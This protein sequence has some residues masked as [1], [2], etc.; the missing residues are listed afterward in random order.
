MPLEP[1]TRKTI[2]QGYQ[3]PTQPIASTRLP[4]TCPR[5]NLY[6]GTT[7]TTHRYAF[8]SL[9]VR[10]RNPNQTCLHVKPAARSRCVSRADLPSSV[11][12][13]N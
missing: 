3:G 10:L 12:W 4:S 1:N 7:Y 13:C 9:D 5:R 11:L 2:K 6:D 8:I